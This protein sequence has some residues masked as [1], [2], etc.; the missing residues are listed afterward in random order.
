MKIVTIGAGSVAWGPRISIDF[1][2]NP[3]LDGAELM[4]M[5]VDAEKVELVRHLLERLVAERGFAKRVRATTDL[6]EALTDAD[7]VLTA[8]S[9]GGDRLWR[10]DAIFPQIYGIFQPVGDTIGP[11]GLV[12]ALRHAPA[13]L[14]IGRT[15]LE[16][17]K[18]NAPLIQLTNPMNP[19]CAALQRLDGLTVYGICHGIDD[20]AAIFAS[21]L[22]VPKTEVAVVAAGNNHHIYC[23]EIRIGDEVYDQDRFD[24]LAPSLFDTPFRAEVYRRYGGLVG[25]YSR[26]PIEF[27]PGFLTQEHQ[28]GRAW[29]VEPLAVQID[30]MRGARQDRER[31]LLLRALA[32][33][34]PIAF[35][36]PDEH[37]G[38]SLD[39]R[40]RVQTRH[41]HERIDEFIVALDRGLP[42][43][44]HLNLPNDGAIAGVPPD[45]HVEIPVDVVDGKLRRRS[46]QF[47]ET[48]TAEIAR[49]GE[50]QKLIADACVELDRDVLIEALSL[51]VLVPNREIA[52]RLVTEMVEFQR[53]YIFPNAIQ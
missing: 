16:V 51:D 29:G 52:T 49:V 40:G 11:G 8:I 13:L 10:Y 46:L 50:E 7:Y 30:P 4:L 41:S 14:S 45:H 28:F 22:G 18:P 37:G 2:L 19:L 25:N 26:H 39:E 47:N 31:E 44:M 33:A 9:V 34:E 35:D 21:T 3:A 43:A 15:M 1:L 20:T 32:Q 6:R 36:S 5:D 23:T 53:E 17:S 38:L 12:R 48:I 42:Y 27:L 24:E